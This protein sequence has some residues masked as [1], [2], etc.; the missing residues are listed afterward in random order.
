MKKILIYGGI[1]LVAI[2]LLS[3]KSIKDVIT[4]TKPEAGTGG[5]NLPSDL[6]PKPGVNTGGGT[7]PG[8]GITVTPPVTPKPTVPPTTAPKPAPSKYDGHVGAESAMINQGI[9][10]KNFYYYDSVLGRPISKDEYVE[11]YL[12]P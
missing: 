6:T 10:P 11:R 4:G 7:K 9:D 12:L 1:A 2:Q 8:D 3:G 5:I